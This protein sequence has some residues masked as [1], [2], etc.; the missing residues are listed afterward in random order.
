[1][2]AGGEL[3]RFLKSHPEVTQV[4]AFLAD[5]NGLPRGKRFPVH[6]AGKI[7]D[8]GVQLPFCLY[9]LDVTGEDLDPGGRSEARGDPDG[10]AFPVAATL[11]PVPWA[12]EPT[13]QVLLTMP[14]QKNQPCLV[15]PRQLLAQLLARFASAGSRR[16][17]GGAGILLMDRK[18]GALGGRCRRSRPPPANR[19]PRA[20]STHRRAR[21]LRRL[22][23][24]RRGC[25]QAAEGAGLDRDRENSPAAGQFVDHL[26]SDGDALRACDH[27]V[28]LRRIIKS[29]APKHG[30]ST[31]FMAMPYLD[32]A[33]SGM[34]VHCSLV[35]A[36]GRNAFD[37]GGEKG[38]ALLRHAIGGLGATTA[39][40]MALL[41]PNVNSFRRYPA[42]LAVPMCTTWGSTTARSVS[43]CRPARPIA[44]H[45][46]R[47]GAD[48][49]LSR[50]RRAPPAC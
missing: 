14:E 41:A 6:E 19:I 26:H 32:R 47:R 24:R 37:D 25:G 49:T 10:N 15:D 4:D 50:G 17:G 12:S 23:A 9:F 5:M 2:Q 1:M 7:W 27:A 18:R 22:R 30:F 31:S 45:R 28:L 11:A 34:H 13:A 38:T 35:D 39:E 29:V 40:A 42:R 43:A 44:P 20:S 46:H 48:A 36:K 8:S 16:C 3:A 33:G 21:H